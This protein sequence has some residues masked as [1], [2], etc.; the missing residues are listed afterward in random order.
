MTGWAAAGAAAAEILGNVYQN[1]ANK[2]E[3]KKNR[4]FQERMA[5]H[6]YQYAM[7]DMKKAGLNPMLAFSQGGATTPSGAQ[8]Q[9]NSPS[10]GVTS[11]AIGAMQARQALKNMEQQESTMA[12]QERQAEATKNLQQQ[13]ANNAWF[14]SR[15]KNQAANYWDS[16]EGGTAKKWQLRGHVAN[17]TTK[18]LGNIPFSKL[19]DS[20][21]G[22]GRRR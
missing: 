8:A 15:E 21:L 6:S 16:P 12:A 18:A 3:A 17:D 19:F 1:S 11:S 22:T 10:S 20:F 2:K 14:D 4:Q 5:R 9:V 7:E 13:L